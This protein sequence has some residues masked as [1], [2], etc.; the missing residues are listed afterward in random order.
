MT[1]PLSKLRTAKQIAHELGCSPATVYR[2]ARKGVL[3]VKKGCSGGRTS[4]LELDVKS[5]EDFR[6]VRKR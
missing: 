1:A 3:P 5:L 2:M 4:R 6:S